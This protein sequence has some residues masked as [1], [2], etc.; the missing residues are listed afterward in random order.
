MEKTPQPFTGIPREWLCKV[1]RSLSCSSK[2]QSYPPYTTYSIQVD[3]LKCKNIHTCYDWVGP[4]TFDTPLF[5]HAYFNHHDHFI[6]L[7]T[8]KEFYKKYFVELL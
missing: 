5:C 8:N 2:P 4:P 7:Y 3:I 1:I 6:T